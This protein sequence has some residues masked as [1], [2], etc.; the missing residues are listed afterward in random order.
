MSPRNDGFSWRIIS[1][2]LLVT[3]L[4]W[5]ISHSQIDK[6]ESHINYKIAIFS[7]AGIAITACE[8]VRL[9]VDAGIAASPEADGVR[10]VA[11][12]G[13]TRSPDEVSEWRRH[14]PG[15]V[16]GFSSGRDGRTCPRGPWSPDNMTRVNQRNW[17]EL[18]NEVCMVA[19]FRRRFVTINERS[20]KSRFHCKT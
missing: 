4:T 19:R 8:R 7:L 15:T 5:S 10:L 11:G 12:G 14:W 9:V 20:T 3:E 16:C 6:G 18:N 1:R 2:A 13:V 17:L